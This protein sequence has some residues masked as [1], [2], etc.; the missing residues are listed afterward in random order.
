MV[1][2]WEPDWGRVTSD[3]CRSK[4]CRPNANAVGWLTYRSLRARAVKLPT[5][6]KVQAINHFGKVIIA[7]E[8]RFSSED[9]DHIRR[10]QQIADSLLELDTENGIV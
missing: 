9:D 5:W 7:T 8:D 10:V 1:Q 6:A 2:A 3:E 4:I